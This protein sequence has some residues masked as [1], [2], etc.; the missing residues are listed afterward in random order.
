MAKVTQVTFGVLSPGNINVNLMSANVTS[1][2]AMSAADLLIDLKSGYLLGANPRQQFLA[3]FFGI[4]SGTIVSV[5]AFQVL[6]PDA[7]HLGTSQFPAPA[8]LTW[9]AVA[10]ALSHGLSALAPIKVWEIGIGGAVGLVLA[11]LPV[12]LSRGRRWIPSPAAIGLSW[13]FP[14]YLSLLFF[15]GGMAA[16]VFEKRRPKAAE[17]YTFPVASGLIAGGSVMG[18]LLVCWANLPDLIA[19]FGRTR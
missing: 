17:A 7:S 12:L 3:Q 1:G 16:F 6:V 5:L 10:E 13:T 19:Q 15:L 14:W 4:F 11:L 8:A 2:A 9:R 18:V